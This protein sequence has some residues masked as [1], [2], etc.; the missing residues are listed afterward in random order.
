MTPN[1]IHFSFIFTKNKCCLGPRET[2]LSILIGPSADSF[3][4]K[5][6]LGTAYLRMITASVHATTS[7]AIILMNKKVKSTALE[8]VAGSVAMAA[9]SN[10]NK[11]IFHM[12]VHPST[13]LRMSGFLSHHFNYPNA[14]LTIDINKFP[15]GDQLSSGDKVYHFVGGTR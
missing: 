4:V 11:N 5:E 1:N 9:I 10:R 2:R 7:A 8:W 14:K 6:S 3:F 12:N 13:G 15:L